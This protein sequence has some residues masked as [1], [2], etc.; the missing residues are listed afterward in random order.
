[1][2]TLERH[3]EVVGTASSLMG[4]LQL[5]VGGAA[6]A[7][8]GL[9]TGGGVQAMVAGIAACGLLAAVLTAPLPRR[10]AIAG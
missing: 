5:A 8:S 4:T 1:M 2:L 9:F 7:L 10:S 3:G 6:M